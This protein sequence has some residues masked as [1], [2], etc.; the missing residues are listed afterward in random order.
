M[1]Y[2]LIGL[3]CAAMLFLLEA[4]IVEPRRFTLRR[5][6]MPCAASGLAR[7]LSIL[8]V[9]DLH[10]RPHEH[11]K[12]R[13]LHRVA[14]QEDVDIVAVTGDLI[15]H[16][17]SIPICVDALRAFKPRLGVFVALGGHDYF[18]TTG[19]DLAR[20]LITR[21]TRRFERVD[22]EQLV[23]ALRSIGVTVLV[24]ARAELNAHGA[25]VDVIGIDDYK[26]GEPDLDA[27]FAGMRKDA[28]TLVMMHEPSMVEEI[29]ERGPDLVLSGHTHGGQ[30]RIP[31]VGALTTQSRLPRRHA[32]GCFQRGRT[33]FH[34]NNGMG[35]GEYT[36]FRIFCP[37]EV[38]V[39]EAAQ[40]QSRPGLA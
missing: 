10:F 15:D 14:S 19:V 36:P 9:T 1:T 5:R 16:T 24:N 13:F 23:A 26:F 25:K 30:V 7:P 32:T 31:G 2:L 3:A 39:I 6:R 11:G 34:L 33:T 38:T 35:T 29:A 20:Q 18:R 28:F 21:D 22:T 8:H 4:V 17:P 12:R 40:A 27:A 37:P